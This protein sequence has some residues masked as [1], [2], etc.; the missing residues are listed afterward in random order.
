[1]TGTGEPFWCEIK[2][3]FLGISLKSAQHRNN[4]KWEETL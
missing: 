4:Q 1:M 3:F 2:T